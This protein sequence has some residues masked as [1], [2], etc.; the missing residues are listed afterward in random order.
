MEDINIIKA[1]IWRL[2][3]E[4]RQIRSAAFLVR[5]DGGGCG[6]P[7]GVQKMLDDRASRVAALRVAIGGFVKKKMW[8]EGLSLEDVLP[9]RADGMINARWHG[10]RYFTCAKGA[11]VT[12][13]VYNGGHSW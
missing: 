7:D 6:Y 13:N 3:D 9:S 1:E 11:S 5:R 8:K 4:A 2:E 10:K 12:F